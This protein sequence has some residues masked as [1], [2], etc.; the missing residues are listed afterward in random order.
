M[1]WLV[2]S[3]IQAGGAGRKT[4]TACPVLHVRGAHEQFDDHAGLERHRCGTES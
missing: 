1:I 3:S 4:P 2:E